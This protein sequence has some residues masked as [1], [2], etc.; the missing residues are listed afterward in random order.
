MKKYSLQLHGDCV[1]F[2]RSAET[3]ALEQTLETCYMMKSFL[4]ELLN[5]EIQTEE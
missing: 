2:T 4:C 1:K 3:L 5:K